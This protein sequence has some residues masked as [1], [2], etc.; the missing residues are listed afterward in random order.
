[1]I[2]KDSTAEAFPSLPA[3]P[4]T[5]IKGPRDI[6]IRSRLWFA[7][8]GSFDVLHEFP[9]LFERRLDLGRVRKD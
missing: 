3:G 4:D 1:M 7:A 5:M 8:T 9:H 2:D 6:S